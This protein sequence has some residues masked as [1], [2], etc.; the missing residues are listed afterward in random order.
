MVLIVALLKVTLSSRDPNSPRNNIMSAAS[1]ATSV[2]VSMAIPTSAW[3]SAVA[4]R[5]LHVA[6]TGG[7][8]HAPNNQ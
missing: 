1:A 3:A 2:P 4:K 8:R 6:Y 7:A 5:T